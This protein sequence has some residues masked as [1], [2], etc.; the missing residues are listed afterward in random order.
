MAVSPDN[1]VQGA[2]PPAGKPSLQDMLQ[3]LHNPPVNTQQNAV[4]QAAAPT[5]PGV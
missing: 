4:S 3:Q 1:P 2:Q 5:P